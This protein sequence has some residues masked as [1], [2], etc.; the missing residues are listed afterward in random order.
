MGVALGKGAPQ[1]SGFPLIFLQRLKLAT[2]KFAR[3]G[4]LP[5]PIIKFHQEEN[6]GLALDGEAP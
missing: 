5:R 1:H 2:S 3:S 6:V 4:G